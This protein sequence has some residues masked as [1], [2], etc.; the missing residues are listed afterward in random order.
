MN[1]KISELSAFSNAKL[2]T[3][4]NAIANVGSNGNKIVRKNTYYTWVGKIFRLSGAKNA[5][6]AVRTELLC[7][8]GRAFDL[9]GVG[10][11][12][13]G[14]TTF[15]RGFMDRLSELL[16]PDF[17]RDDFGIGNDG[18]VKSGQPLT[19]RRIKA[20]LN[21][22]TLVGRTKNED[23]DIKAAQGKSWGMVMFF[24]IATCA[25]GV[26]MLVNPFKTE[27]P[28]F[29]VAG[30]GFLFD[31]ITDF[32]TSFA[33]GTSKA[34]YERLAGSAPVIELEPGAAQTL[35]MEGNT[36]ATPALSGETAEPSAETAPT[37]AETAPAPKQA[38]EPSASE[39]IAVT[40]EEAMR[41]DETPKSD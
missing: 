8:L 12:I 23:F 1:F 16:G 11:N 24:G 6:N 13:A 2:G 22:A 25:V 17:R 7:A 35:P 20:I 37:P 34:R 27:G 14:K 38:P 10:N 39:P 40:L 15:S 4:Y 28:L 26:L 21:R 32:F 3:S 18:P 41:G 5:N 19:Q 29:L 30:I 31:G 36:A 9:E 33:V